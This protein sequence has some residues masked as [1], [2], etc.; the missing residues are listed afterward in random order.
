MKY[1]RNQ[2]TIITVMCFSCC[3]L[4]IKL[5]DLKALT[6]IILKQ[7]LTTGLQN[8]VKCVDLNMKQQGFYSNRIGN[9]IALFWT[10]RF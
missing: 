7:Q 10:L 6:N 1:E 4:A 3:I 9:S 2:K 5:K 8:R